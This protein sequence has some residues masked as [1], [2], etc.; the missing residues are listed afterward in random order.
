VSVS[1]SVTARSFVL[2][3]HGSV[4]VKMTVKTGLMKS[5]AVNDDTFPYLLIL[6]CHCMCAIRY[7]I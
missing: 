7:Y 4:I 5:S 6:T 3:T 1:F 2:T